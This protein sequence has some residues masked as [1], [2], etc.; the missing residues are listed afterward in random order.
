MKNVLVL[1]SASAFIFYGSLCLL[2][3]HMK[4][5]FKRYGL[6]KYR[7]LTGILEMQGGIGLILGLQYKPLMIL[8]SSG[9]M[10]LMFMGTLV[11]IR[12][13]D[14]LVQIIPAFCLMLVN[15]YILYT[16]L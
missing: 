3:N 12:M 10:I 15:A 6:V 16:A 11:R 4:D 9:L 7:T 13:K 5:E 14:P 1:F 2:S 8:S